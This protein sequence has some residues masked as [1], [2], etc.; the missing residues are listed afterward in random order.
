[1]SRIA[2][3]K[4]HP[5]LNMALP[6]LSGDLIRAGHK[7]RMFFF[8]DYQFE[9]EYLG[10][11]F[12]DELSDNLPVDMPTE[13]EEIYEM[14]ATRIESFRPDALGLS[15]IS[16][17]IPEAI[18]TTHFLRNRFNLPIIWGGVGATLEPEIAIEHADL[19]CVGEGEEVLVEFADCLDS[20]ADWSQIEGSWARATDG[21]VIKNPKR[22]LGSL[23]KI[24]IPDW[25]SKK[26]IYVTERKAITGKH[27]HKLV[28]GRDYQIM[29]Q[30]G[31][32]FSCSFC[33]ESRYQEMFG[34]KNSLRRRSIDLVIEELVRAKEEHEPTVVWFW[35][36]VFTVNPRWLRDFLPRYKEEVDI[37]F[38]CYTYPTTHNLG[39]LQD[40]KAAGCNCI[41]MG[42]Q[43]GSERILEDVY[44]RPTPLNRVI[45][46]SQEIVDA[47]IIG[48]FD[49]I[50]KSSFET[51]EDLR[52]TYNF[53][54]DL[55]L[56]MV[57]LGAGDMKSYPTYAYSR[58]EQSTRNGELLASS[59][60]VSDA[61]Y[62]YYHNLYWV[63]RNPF[64]SKEEKLDIGNTPVFRDQPKLLKQ[65]IHIQPEFDEGLRHM[66]G[67]VISGEHPYAMQSVPVYHHVPLAKH[68]LVV[69]S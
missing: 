29:T 13:F 30:R 59:T 5:G 66:R 62:D 65:Y 15:V 3:I 50:S 31:C 51:E 18:K 48:Y 39:L 54:I 47:G 36:D 10:S 12:S 2:I 35:D 44:N 64:I 6:Q 26:M 11:S 61:I 34:K 33:V 52:A 60:K 7:S 25:D 38:W 40:L 42:I 22:A 49:L 17:S 14:L 63:A 43:S 45:E 8:K 24:A 27:A 41:S 28:S 57:Y 19:V 32:P 16:L 20:G 55:P 9:R 37:P 58:Q 68:P 53:L 56:E 1:M 67:A 4:I 69:T 21:T 23:D 46:A